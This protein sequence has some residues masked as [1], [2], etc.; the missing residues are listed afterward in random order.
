MPGIKRK[1]S[2]SRRGSRKRS[3]G[4]KRRR[5][6]RKSRKSGRS[7]NILPQG[8]GTA[9][10][11]PRIWRHTPYSGLAASSDEDSDY[12]EEDSEGELDELPEV[13]NAHESKRRL[14]APSPAKRSPTTRR[15]FFG[16][17]FVGLN[18]LPPASI[19]SKSDCS[20]KQHPKIGS[21]VKT[22]SSKA[23]VLSKAS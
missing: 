5:T 9:Q 6:T 23:E 18:E 12:V 8:I 13:P 3:Y 14:S 2:R 7:L 4:Y 1:R 10:F 20:C 17:A 15:N 21:T 16:L 11:S 22:T 19:A